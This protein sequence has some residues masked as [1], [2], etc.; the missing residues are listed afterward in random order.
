MDREPDLVVLAIH[1]FFNRFQWLDAVTENT[2][3]ISAYLYIA[4]DNDH[5]ILHP[6]ICGLLVYFR[7]NRDADCTIHVFQL[8]DAHGIALLGGNT[9]GLSNR[10]SDHDLLSVHVFGD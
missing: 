4:M 2:R 7:E 1:L 8:D 6:Q 3:F 5:T 10:A 9:P